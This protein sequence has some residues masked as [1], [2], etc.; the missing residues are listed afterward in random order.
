VGGHI[1]SLFD[2]RENI[3]AGEEGR[4]D[5]ANEQ[6]R[7]LNA[8]VTMPAPSSDPAVNVANFDEAVTKATGASGYAGT[9]V[10]PPGKYVFDSTLR[11]R[12]K[13]GLRVM[14]SGCATQ[15]EFNVADG[16]D[17]VTIEHSQHCHWSDMYLYGAGSGIARAAFALLRTNTAG[18]V[19]A[20]SQCHIHD[21]LVDCIN[22]A[23]SAITIG[24]AD[25]NNDFHT[26]ERCT[27]QNY[28]VRGIDLRY[29][30]QSYANQFRN[31]RMYAGSGALYGVDMGTYVGATF[32]WEG[33]FMHA[34]GEADFRLSRSYQSVNIGGGFNS[35][36]SARFLV[37]D[38]GYKQISVRD[39][40]W[41]GNGLH[42]DNRA[43]IWAY[44]GQL[45]IT[46]SRIGDGNDPTRALVID[47]PSGILGHVSFRQNRVY[48][49]AAAVFTNGV[50]GD[51]FGND[52][53]TNEVTGTTL[54][55]LA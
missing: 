6:N 29:N 53:T 20:P 17:W 48:S 55:L 33:G 13:M 35:E 15:L 36:G 24:G 44:E 51:M 19:Y 14:G 23:E 11:V 28:T 3:R 5:T 22:K 32:T 37:C 47:L 31:V 42:E 46:N 10:F 39:V 41:A 16:V 21:V 1:L 2:L 38:G 27:L 12:N 18:S 34:H 25:A 30:M 4:I 9:V 49:S 40:R 7:R 54:A 8:V 43:I 50:P 45:S 52:K 26:V